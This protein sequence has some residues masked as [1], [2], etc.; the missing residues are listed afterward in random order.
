MSKIVYTSVRGRIIDITEVNDVV[1]SDKVLGDGMAII[2]TDGNICAPIDGIVESI[3][4]TNH[5]FTIVGDE[6]IQ[7]LVH[8][9][10]ETVSLNGKP[11]RRLVEVGSRVKAGKPII[12]ANLKK[13]MKKGLDPVVIIV[14]VEG[15]IE[16]KTTEV[17]SGAQ[18]QILFTVF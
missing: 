7:I 13:I 16:S 9:G 15:K 10:L 5:A 8:I 12:K 17:E 11:F 4:P 3:F 1:F 6:G 2:P 14:L 18:E